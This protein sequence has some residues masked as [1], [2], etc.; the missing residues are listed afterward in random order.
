LFRVVAWAICCAFLWNVASLSAADY[1]G[2]VFPEDLIV[3]MEYVEPL[4]LPK[5]SPLLQRP[6]SQRSNSQQVVFDDLDPVNSIIASSFFYDE[7]DAPPKVV[8][9]RQPARV[10]SAMDTDDIVFTENGEII[11]GGIVHGGIIGASS[12]AMES[13]AIDSFPVPFGMGL[14]DNVSLFSES[15]AFKTGLS[16]GRGSLGLSE[17]INWSAAVTPQ[18]AV[19]AQYGVRAVQGDLFNSPTRNQLFMTAGL[20]KRFNFASVQGGVAVDWLRDHTQY[21]TIN[22]RQM[23]CE[24]STRALGSLE[25]G[26]IGGFNVFQ[27]RPAI[28]YG[29]SREIVDVHDYYLLFIRKHLGNG[30]QME[31]RCGSTAR[32]DFTMSALGEA[33]ITD[34]LAVNGGI[35]MLAPS[36]G[37]RMDG[38]HREIWSLSLGVV[39]YFRGG[40]VFRQMNSYRPMFDVAGNNSFFTRIVGR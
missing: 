40:A 12:C 10:A 17:G 21:G 35:T 16:G 30:G 1:R 3:D 2:P 24:L 27:D 20:F 18:G 33:A 5:R 6:Q 15:T 32:G 22:L 38:N 4:P 36:G 7:E 39:L 28:G 8:R 9:Q 13:Y 29:G 25:C 31:L 23:R 11:H 26:F 37:Q 19:T 34:R 14:F